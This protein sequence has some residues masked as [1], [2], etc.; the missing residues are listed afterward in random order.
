M[1]HQRRSGFD[2]V[3]AAATALLGV[4]SIVVAFQLGIGTSA[5]PGPGAWPLV[6]GVAM[7]L[8]DVWFVMRPEEPLADELALPSRWG[9]F[10]IALAS[11]F[12]TRS[13]ST[14]WA[15]SSRRHCCCSCN[16]AGS[17]AATGK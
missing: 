15:I 2:W 16:C 12:G 1:G 8:L 14:R 13:S 7:L 10:A 4:M 3:V 17:R 11:L 5:A 6:V 9:K